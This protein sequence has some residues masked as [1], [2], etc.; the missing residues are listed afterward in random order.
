M[1][2]LAKKS[3]YSEK[4]LLLKQYSKESV[5]I[6]FLFLLVV[7]IMKQALKLFK[8]LYV[9]IYIHFRQLE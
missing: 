2:V 1:R 5:S 7:K 8:S 9:D 4:F 3:C 6:L